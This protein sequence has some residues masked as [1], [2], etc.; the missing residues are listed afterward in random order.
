M[1]TTVFTN[2]SVSPASGLRPM[3][4]KPNRGFARYQRKN[5]HL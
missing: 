3:L 4:Q 1:F 2:P 5:Q